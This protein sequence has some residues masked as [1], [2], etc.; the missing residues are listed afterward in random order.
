V[1]GGAT[2]IICEVAAAGSTLAAPR[3]RALPAVP[4]WPCPLARTGQ[5]AGSAGHSWSAPESA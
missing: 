4:S 1:I 3:S 2:A 5:R